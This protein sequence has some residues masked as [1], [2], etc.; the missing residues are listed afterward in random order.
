[1][2]QA[3]LWQ[4]NNAPVLNSLM[5]SKQTWYDE[6]HTAFWNDW[7][8]DV[9]D[10]RTCNLFGMC[11]WA[12]I[13]G[14]PLSIILDPDHTTRQAFGFKPYGRNFNHA[15]FATIQQVVTKLTLEEQ[16]I[17][18]QLRYFQLIS[19]GAVPATNRFLARIFVNFGP[20]FIRDHL[21][22]TITYKFQFALSSGLRFVLS[23]YDLLPR[24]TGVSVK[25]I[26]GT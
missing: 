4:H 13:L 6:N 14:I 18:L 5:A 8:T 23:N 15:N 2:L 24:D 17:V 22:M 7:Y 10:L 1:M 9:F 11:V 21:D 20:A 25:I 26:S 16:R 12:I 19:N 3:L